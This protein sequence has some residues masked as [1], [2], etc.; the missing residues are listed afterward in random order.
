MSEPDRQAASVEDLPPIAPDYRAQIAAWARGFYAEGRSLAGSSVSEPVPARDSKGRLVWLVCLDVPSPAAATEPGQ[1]LHAFGFA[2]NYMSAP[3]RRNGSSLNPDDC[4]KRPL[5]WRPWPAGQE[6]TVLRR[7][8][9][10]TGVRQPA[11][12][13][14]LAH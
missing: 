1:T 12:G 9:T 10:R 5:R 6:G 13:T 3:L 4:A 11:P 2:P 14:S 7:V 8:R